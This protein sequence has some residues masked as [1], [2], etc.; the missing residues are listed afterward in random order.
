MHKRLWAPGQAQNLPNH[1]GR[2]Q[3]IN[4]LE[5]ALN[6]EWQGLSIQG[7]GQGRHTGSSRPGAPKPGV[8]PVPEA[9]RY[10]A[11]GERMER[12]WRSNLHTSKGHLWKL[13]ARANTSLLS[14]SEVYIFCTGQPSITQS[15]V[16]STFSVV[17][18]EEAMVFHMIAAP[19]QDQSCVSWGSQ[20]EHCGLG[21]HK[22]PDDRATVP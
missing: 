19:L 6:I 2:L 20:P 8:S 18:P 4:Q 10:A 12:H 3:R 7:R 1:P 11:V 13:T 17:V 9:G 21:S 14:P 5:T 16:G 22:G 15:N